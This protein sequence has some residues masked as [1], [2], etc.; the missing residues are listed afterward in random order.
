[1]SVC[2]NAIS[3]TEYELRA[4][5]PLADCTQYVALDAETYRQNMTFSEPVYDMVMQH[6]I[7][8]LVIG[9]GTGLVIAII[10]KLKR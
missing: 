6:I 3:T 4:D 1:M 10:A 5:I 9:M 2:I 8:M 7:M